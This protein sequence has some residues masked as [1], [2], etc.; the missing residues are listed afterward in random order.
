MAYDKSELIKYRIERAKETAI[1]AKRNLDDGFLFDAMN[2]IYYS[3]FYIVT[4]LAI[5]CNFST[6]KHQQLLGW[7]NLTYIKTGKIDTEFYKI[8]SK[9]YKYRQ[10]G[11]YEDFVVFSNDEL[12]EHYQNMLHFILKI[13][14][15]INQT[16]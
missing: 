8:Y 10:K 12:L 15:E 14:E 9:A 4:A 5:K 7:F 11:D 16:N 1:V 13:E 6:S 2:R 3:I